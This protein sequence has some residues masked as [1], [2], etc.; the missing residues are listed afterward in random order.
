MII[1]D[2]NKCLSFQPEGSKKQRKQGDGVV[3]SHPPASPGE[4]KGTMKHGDDVTAL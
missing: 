4:S 3:A 2:W 1:F